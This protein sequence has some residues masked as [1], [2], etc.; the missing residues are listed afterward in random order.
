[1]LIVQKRCSGFARL[2]SLIHHESGLLLHLAVQTRSSWT[3]RTSDCLHQGWR[4]VCGQDSQW[5]WQKS[6]QVNRAQSGKTNP[7][8]KMHRVKS[9]MCW[10]NRCIT[11]TRRNHHL[12]RAHDEEEN[13]SKFFFCFLNSSHL[14]GVIRSK[15]STWSMDLDNC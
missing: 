1:M 4:I 13:H 8:L 12:L 6:G 10:A 7:V 9:W 14:Y 3:R 15:F 11:V 5:P 2:V